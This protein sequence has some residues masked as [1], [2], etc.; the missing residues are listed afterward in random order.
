[1]ESNVAFKKERIVEKGAIKKAFGDMIATNDSA[2][3]RSP[4]GADPVYD[5]YTIQDIKEIIAEGDY[6]ALYY[7]SMYFYRCSGI[8]KR[9]INYFSCLLTYDTII[10]PKFSGAAIAKGKVK[11]RF[12]AA[13]QFVNDFNAKKNC[14]HM[15]QKI[16]SE[17]VYYGLLRVYPNSVTMQDL[18]FKYCRTRFKNKYGINL[19]EFN[20]QFFDTLFNVE[21]DFIN[22][23][24]S[25]PQEII[26]ALIEYKTK[27]G[28][29]WYLVPSDL[30]ICFYYEDLIPYFV[31]MLTAIFHYDD[32]Q[33]R[34][35][36][37]D[38][39]ELQKLLIHKVPIDTKNGELFFEPDEAAEMHSGI[40]KMLSD[41][42]Y[43][44][45]LTTYGEVTLEQTQDNTGQAQ[46]DNLK[47]FKN[48]VFDESGTSSELFNAEGNTALGKSIDK[49]TALAIAIADSF[50]EWLTYQL[51][52]RFADSKMSF[53]VEFLPITQFNRKD[54]A[55]MY[56]QGAQYGYSKFYAGVAYGIDQSNLINMITLENDIY[57]LTDKMIPLQ[58]SYTTPG[59][60]KEKK[61]DKTDEKNINK[62][63]QN[64]TNNEGGRPEKA[65]EEKSDKTIQNKN[66]E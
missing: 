14:K 19:I 30:G 6:D 17:G 43:I 57:G 41:N 44:D 50:S 51:N 55:S 4:R 35:V 48:A 5:N 21:K 25:Y 56:V 11:N 3:T 39:E 37:R 20:L 33:E 28:P 34:E 62:T 54:M 49:D 2:Y 16:F 42:K 18:P 46:R 7:L 8:Y 58:S 31:G 47:K 10:T 13:L 1:M 66:S 38:S 53:A 12:N 9:L 32:S 23:L 26:R 45:V 59:G 36:D 15:M 60:E 64:D 29:Q 63:S 22:V 24:K 65:D 27:G 61:D 40:V 52:L